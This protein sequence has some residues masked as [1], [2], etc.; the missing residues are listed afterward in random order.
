ME[1]RQN[2]HRFKKQRLQQMRFY[3]AMALC[4]LAWQTTHA[5]QVQ[6]PATGLI[7]IP[8]WE[9]RGIPDGW[10]PPA[11]PTEVVER[12]AMP[13]KEADSRSKFD[14]PLTDD[15]DALVNDGNAPNPF[16]RTSQGSVVSVGRSFVANN[17]FRFFPCD[18]AMAI[19]DSGYIV[20]A[21]NYTIEYY[22]DSPDSLLQN[23]L[24]DAF[25]NDASL[26]GLPF[27]PRVIY[28]RYA[29]RFILVMLAYADSAANKILLS[30]SKG[31][32][33]RNG[34]YHYRINSDTLTENK[35][36]DYASIAVNKNELFISGNVLSDAGNG[37]S[38]NKIFQIRKKEILQGQPMSCRVWLDVVDADGDK[39]FTIVPLADGLMRDKYDRGIFLVS[40]DLVSATV[41]SNDLNWYQITDSLD[42]PGVSL[43]VHEAVAGIAY[44]DAGIGLQLTGD[45][46]RLADARVLSG[47]F[48]DSVLNFV[49]CKNTNNYSTI[50]LNRL[51]IGSNVNQRY[52]WGFTDNFFD[53]TFPSIAF[54]GSD[55]VDADNIMM[56]FQRTSSGT[57][58]ELM[59]VNFQGDS[60][61]VA[62]TVVRQGDGIIE[63][64][65]GGGLERWGDYTAIQRRYGANPKACW[66]AGS[67]PFGPNP[68]FYGQTN[69]L[70]TFVAEVA[71][72]FGVSVL[73]PTSRKQSLWVYPNP[74]FGDVT[75]E[76]RGQAQ[77]VDQLE[78]FDG[79]GRV[80]FSR[81][82]TGQ[83]P[84]QLNLQQQA[85]GLYFVRLTYKD[86]SHEIQKL[87]LE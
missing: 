29:E 72:S 44:T 36:F 77:M 1:T 26:S 64:I 46:I 22:D 56:C 12:G 81:P 38:G 74:S 24:H 3:F 2:F 79:V 17:L 41:S 40:T 18:N 69:G 50:V 19:S 87:V 66:L 60:F 59:A 45:A 82:W 58:P 33:P 48:L 31:Q 86:R 76:L 37:F 25:Y 71:D 20:S 6:Y 28:D 21:D 43:L 16:A 9:G 5:Q 47:F 8:R 63:I 4:L 65:P 7:T 27:D 68:N 35:W 23:Q 55:S 32:D 15:P 13:P 61:A 57:Y 30:V 39:G 10:T 84:L 42:A 51:H 53:Y 49:Y 70:N 75:L 14:L 62:S 80:V 54:W 52:P 83:A 78:V 11:H 67:Y 73:G 34:W 85:S